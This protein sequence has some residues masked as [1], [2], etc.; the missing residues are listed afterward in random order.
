MLA[1]LLG[2]TET[3]GEIG[4]EIEV[5]G[6][7][8]PNS[9]MVG[10]LWRC[11]ADPSLRGESCE[12]V[13]RKP[14]DRP[15]IALALD[16]LSK[17]YDRNRTSVTNGYRAG[18]HIHVNVQDLTPRQ[19]IN[20]I[21]LYFMFEECLIRFCEQS[22]LGNHFCLRVSDASHIVTL[23]TTAITT[24]NLRILN[25]DEIR[26]SSLNLTALFKY[27][28]VEFRALES[29][30]DWGK[31]LTWIDLLLSLK[32]HAKTVENPTDLLG[33]CS[34]EGPE[35]FAKTVFGKFY[36]ILKNHLVGLDVEELIYE[37][38]RNIQFPIFSRDWNL[39]NLNIFRL[40]E[41]IFAG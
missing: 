35:K 32:K 25:T 1:S 19:L 37:G 16:A 2:V 26:Y 41:D 22:R 14:L 9:D 17:A 24:G 6:S 7:R 8:L 30:N 10:K 20:F 21:T 27:G 23:L 18:I 39:K 38:V 34:A 28:S 33:N 29:T 13:L 4:V 15:E 40:Q 11:E 5:E 36:P 12:Y 31:I 3:S